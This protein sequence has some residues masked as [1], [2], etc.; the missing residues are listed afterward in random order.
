MSDKELRRKL[1][2]IV[3]YADDED[4]MEI[5]ADYYYQPVVPLS[6]LKDLLS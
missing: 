4:G 1:E 5:G 3:E 2:E 6:R